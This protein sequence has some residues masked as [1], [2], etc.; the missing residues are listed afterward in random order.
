MAR[1][2][3]FDIS[4][5]LKVD[6]E[7]FHRREPEPEQDRAWQYVKAY[8]EECRDVVLGIVSRPLFESRLTKHFDSG[9]SAE[10]DCSWYALRNAVYATGCRKVMSKEQPGPF[11]VGKGHGWE[12]LQNA[13]NVHSELLYSRTNFM[14]IQALTIMVCFYLPKSM[15]HPSGAS[16]TLLTGIFRGKHRFSRA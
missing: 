6:P 7:V 4:Q 10:P 9:A 14:A 1:K 8:F 3:T 13:L 12:Y 11:L 15:D 16:L 5:H 2:L